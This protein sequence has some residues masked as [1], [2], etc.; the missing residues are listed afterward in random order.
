LTKTRS[1]KG[2]FVVLVGGES[3]SEGAGHG[4]FIWGCK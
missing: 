2:E 1:L 4:K 3:L